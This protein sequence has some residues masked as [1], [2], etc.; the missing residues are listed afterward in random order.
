MDHLLNLQV[1]FHPKQTFQ[2]F[3]TTKPLGI[4]LPKAMRTLQPNQRVT[5][6]MPQQPGQH[7][8]AN[9][10]ISRMDK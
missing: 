5:L 4:Q 1:Q 6:R 2:K 8:P 10:S 3:R 7:N 9:I